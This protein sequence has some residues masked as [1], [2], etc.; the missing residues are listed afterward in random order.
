M[1]QG[2]RPPCPTGYAA[3]AWRN[4]RNPM[5]V[6]SGHTPSAVHEAF[7][8]SIENGT[9][10]KMLAARLANCAEVVPRPVC[11]ILDIPQGSTYAQAAR[12]LN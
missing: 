6:A 8:Q 5:T 2:Q 9:P 4:G 7:V 1:A 12:S 10:S 3:R 11:R